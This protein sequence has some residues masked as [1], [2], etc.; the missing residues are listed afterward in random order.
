[1]FLDKEKTGNVH[2]SFDNNYDFNK[3]EEDELIGVDTVG[4]I[5]SSEGNNVSSDDGNNFFAVGADE[6][7]G[8]DAINELEDAKNV[9]MK[10]TAMLMRAERNRA[11]Y[12]ALD[13]RMDLLISDIVQ[14]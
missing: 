3:G 7:V 2:D 14:P 4:A 12:D 9:G 5:A 1:M 10:N 6:D 8:M 13:K 11:F